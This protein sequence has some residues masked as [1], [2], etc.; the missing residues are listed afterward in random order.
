MSTIEPDVL[1][2]YFSGNARSPSRFL[3]AQVALDTV[4]A[5]S[6]SSSQIEALASSNLEPR[7]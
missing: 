5:A 4:N 2:H 7:L 6:L 3:S 1:L